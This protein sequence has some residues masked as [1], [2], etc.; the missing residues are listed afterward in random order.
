MSSPPCTNIE[1]LLM[2]FWRRSGWS[3][4]K[5]VYS[6]LKRLLQKDRKQPKFLNEVANL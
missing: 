3:D 2:T 6:G 4:D 1:P 5:V